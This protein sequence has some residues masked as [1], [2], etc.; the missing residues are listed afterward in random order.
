MASESIY[1]WIKE[2]PAPPEKPELYRSKHRASAGTA[3]PVAST[4]RDAH[5]KKAFGIMGRELKET[6]KPTDFLRAFS[7]T[8]ATVRADTL[9][10]CGSTSS[11]CHA[12]V[13]L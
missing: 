3:L 1:N 6:V 8:A 10:T 4:L 5:K 12:E 13:L 2:A 11:R 7:K 9:R